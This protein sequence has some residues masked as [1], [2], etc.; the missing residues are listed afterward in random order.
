M[1]DQKLQSNIEAIL[2][3][4]RL[5]SPL[6][7]AEHLGIRVQFVQ[8]QDNSFAGAIKQ[9]PEGVTIFVNDKDNEKRKL[10]TI[11]HELGHFFLHTND[12]N[13]GIISYRD[14]ELY[15][16]YD[17]EGRR[18]EEEANH[19][20]AELLMPRE[21]FV[22]YFLNHSKL[23]FAALISEMGGFF[24]VSESAIKI[25]LAYLDLIS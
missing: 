10:F 16:K 11:A 17:V 6:D 15:S 4:Y 7:L 23:P 9:L 22:S 14:S 12:L 8:D 19:F 24:G 18:K 13:S 20:A 3:K 21:I 25:R 5:F 1:I 2:D